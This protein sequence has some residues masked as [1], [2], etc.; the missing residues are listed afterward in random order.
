MEFHMQLWKKGLETQKIAPYL[1][2]NSSSPKLELKKLGN[3]RS[4]LPSFFGVVRFSRGG[5]NETLATASTKIST[6]HL[7]RYHDFE[8]FQFRR[9]QSILPRRRLGG[10]CAQERSPWNLASQ[11]WRCEWRIHELL[12]WKK[13]GTGHKHV[14]QPWWF[15]MFKL[16]HHPPTPRIWRR[17]PIKLSLS[18][19]FRWGLVR[20]MKP[21][22][23]VL[24]N[25]R[26][27]FGPPRG[28][29][30]C[31]EDLPGQGERIK[32]AATKGY[33]SS[34]SL[35]KALQNPCFSGVIQLPNKWATARRKWFIAR[36]CCAKVFWQKRNNLEIISVKERRFVSEMCGYIL[37]SCVHPWVGKNIHHLYKRAAILFIF[38]FLSLRVGPKL[39]ISAQGNMSFPYVSFYF[40]Q[41]F[42]CCVLVKG[43]V[44]KN[45]HPWEVSMLPNTRAGPQHKTSGRFGGRIN[46]LFWRII[47]GRT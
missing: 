42:V 35:N 19:F 6:C 30:S 34:L 47:P 45:C 16:P 39:I 26:I 10:G 36:H 12:G 40:S 8:R 7:P 38:N 17:L 14:E 15:G 2:L 32:T 18:I 46:S 9:F 37:S 31:W 27:S 43:A 23:P 13:L 24:Q 28:M 3:T 1:K 29:W 22:E 33:Y 44:S 21:I 5:K 41:D 25:L 20:S 11:W 4:G